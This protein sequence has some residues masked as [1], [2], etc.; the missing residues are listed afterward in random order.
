MSAIEQLED[1]LKADWKNLAEARASAR[2]KK[3]ELSKGIGSN[4]PVDTS[5][6][7]FGSLARNEFSMGSD[8]D[9]TL[10]IDGQAS[11]QH[12][13]DAFRIDRILHENDNKRPGREGTFGGPAFSHDIINNIGGN[14][15]TNANTTQ[16]ILLLLESCAI[17]NPDA[18]DRVFGQIL[19]R[20][21]IE[22]WGWI[23]KK[24]AVPRFLLN[25]IVRYWRTVAVDFGYKRRQRQGQGWA[26]RTVKLRMSRKLTYASG[27]LACFSFELDEELKKI[28]SEE[29]LLDR[30]H[31]AVDYLKTQMQKTPL[32]IIAERIL[33]HNSLHVPAK[34]LVDNYDKFIGILNNEE[35]RKHLEEL[36]QEDAENDKLYEQARHISECFQNGLNGIFF[37]ENGIGIFRLTKKYGIF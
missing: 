13:D 33:K 4:A 1:V 17:G 21:I 3:E 10:L 37:E 8:I 11:H 36:S 19:N 18:Y 14:D 34:E 35:Q 2:E 12:L 5:I 26:L 16:R 29:L 28:W 31:P 25:D 20:Y 15:D 27:L 22:D 23:Y 30:K 7:I 32:D 6:T 24:I 9:W